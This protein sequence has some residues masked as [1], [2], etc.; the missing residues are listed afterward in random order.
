N[1]PAEFLDVKRSALIEAF[2]MANHHFRA[3]GT[4]YGQLYPPGSIP[5]KIINERIRHLVQRHWFKTLID[6]NRWHQVRRQN[7]MKCLSL[8]RRIPINHI[9]VWQR[10]SIEFF[11][12]IVV[13]SVVN[14]VERYRPR[15][16]LP[17]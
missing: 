6:S 4:F 17:G 1:K 14:I 7:T 10:P 5:A 11:T 16:K 3:C 12:G 13:F 2:S 9:V 8:K 15:E